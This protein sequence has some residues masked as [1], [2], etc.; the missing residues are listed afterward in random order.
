MLECEYYVCKSSW[1]V[2][3]KIIAEYIDY[4][5]NDGNKAIKIG[6]GLWVKFAEKSIFEGE[7]FWEGDLS[8]I[9]EGLKV[10]ENKIV[11][12]SKYCKTLIVLHSIQI[13]PCDFQEEGLTVAI[14]EWAAR[15]F[16]FQAP[17][18]SVYFDKGSNRYIFEF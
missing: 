4:E 13:A 3:V 14:I 10:V 12:R 7:K 9:V 6:D 18:I 2:Y 15:A 5:N 1:G 8:Y 11:E 16:N 17:K